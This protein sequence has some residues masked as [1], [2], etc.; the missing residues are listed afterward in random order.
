MGNLT[1]SGK[2]RARLMRILGLGFGLAVVFGSTV[3]VG[4][5][6]LPG[7]VA[8]QLGNSWWILAVWI[9]GGIYTLL[10]AASIAELAAMLPQAGGFYVY[11]KRAFGSAVGF[12]VGW[13]DWL[14]NCAVL[15]FGS[16]A[17]AEY[18]SA[19]TS[20]MA[21]HET[22]VALLLLA[23]LTLL[24]WIGLRVSSVVLQLSSSATAVTLIALAS[25][26][27][28]HRGT[29]DSALHHPLLAAP[30]STLA[31]FAAL[32]LAF[33]A[34]IVTYDGWYEAIYFAEEDKNPARNLPLAMIGG[35][36]L[37]VALYVL[38]N[39]AFLLVM[40]MD[41]L[42]A[43]KL[44]AADAAQIVF[45]SSSFAHLSGKFVTLLS[46]LTLI[47][48]VNSVML[49]APRILF[50]VGRDGLFTHKMT[51]VS[52]TGTPRPALLLSSLAAAI[53]IASGTFEN[54]VTVAAFFVASIYCLNYVAL[55]TLR[56]RDPEA[57]RPFCAWGYPWSTGIVLLGPFLFLVAAIHGEPVAALR[58]FVLLAISVPV[59]L[60]MTRRFRFSRP[61]S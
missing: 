10:G 17:A 48:L 50:A 20:R 11:A 60:W 1:A 37:I 52:T 36:V 58:A 23:S 2:P 8:A 7:T 40:P 30:S 14:N 34:V 16:V 31:I 44:P 26:C 24:H 38:M 3:G 57:Q 45:A 22:A 18:L 51:V 43:S 5:L 29:P 21:G 9:G 53:L 12:T 19:L 13:G 39:V 59:Y 61:D 25:A 4:I 28:F 47:S 41:E 49:G 6:R 32:I 35:V 55:F 33:R 27:F 54:I 56:Q 15:A 46:L 42:A